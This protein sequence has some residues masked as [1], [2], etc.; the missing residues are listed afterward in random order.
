MKEKPISSEMNSTV[1]VGDS[2]T[3]PKPP[4]LHKDSSDPNN[5]HGEHMENS[6]KTSTKFTKK[7][8]SR[9]DFVFCLVLVT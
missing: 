1:D 9:G 5:T 4:H 8:L 7:K 2:V 6:P 3:S